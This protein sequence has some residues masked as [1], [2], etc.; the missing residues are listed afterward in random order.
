[1]YQSITSRLAVASV[2]CY[3]PMLQYRAG[4][5]ARVKKNEKN[6]ELLVIQVQKTPFS[7]GLRLN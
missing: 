3:A 5:T 4:Q 7:G 6:A 1:M 2:L